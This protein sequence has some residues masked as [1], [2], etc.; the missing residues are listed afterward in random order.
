VHDGSGNETM[1][2]NEFYVRDI[3]TVP[4][5][6]WSIGLIIWIVAAVGRRSGKGG[7]WKW[8]LAYAFIILSAW[9]AWKGLGGNPDRNP[10]MGNYIGDAIVRSEYSSTKL[11]FFLFASFLGPIITVPLLLI[12]DNIETKRMRDIVS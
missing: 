7:R 9:A 12:V 4:F 8:I 5:T 10:G 3:V 1:D 6:I 2:P 11:V